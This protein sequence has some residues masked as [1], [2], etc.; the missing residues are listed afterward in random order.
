M[1][2]PVGF[3]INSLVIVYQK[4][5]MSSLHNPSTIKQQQYNQR[6]QTTPKREVKSYGIVDHGDVPY[7]ITD[8]GFDILQRTTYPAGYLDDLTPD[9]RILDVGTGDGHFVEDLHEKGFTSA[10]GI[11]IGDALPEDKP[12]LKQ[13]AIENT[14]YPDNTFDRIFSSYSIFCYPESRD[15]QQQA[16]EKM[17]AML[18]PGGHI[19]LAP[20]L[21]TQT[22]KTVV[23]RVPSLRV[24]D[25]GP[26]DSYI[27]LTKVTPKSPASA[28]TQSIN[29][30]A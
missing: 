4:T 11:D 6:Y 30:V 1:Q 20:L 27:Q 25:E 7:S 14:N 21:S 19:R 28:S 8:R 24:S 9:M 10:E 5:A 18:K 3:C 13:V 26:G 17:A 22:L 12:Y 23:A 15:F 29:F 16:L 2:F